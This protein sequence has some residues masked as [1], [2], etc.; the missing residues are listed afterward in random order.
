[1]KSQ[2]PK[3]IFFGTPEFSVKILEALR[4]NNLAPDLIIT[5]PDK[6]VGRKM[7]LTSSAVKTWAKTHNVPVEYDYKNLITLKPDIGIVASFGKIIPADILKIPRYG[8]LNV[9]P[10]LLPKFRG[11]SPIQS[12]ILSGD[13][14]TGV[15]IMLLNEK[16]D[17]GLILTNNKLQISNNIT[18]KEL[19]EKLAELG[20]K[21]LVETIPKW[22][23]GEIKP[24]LQ[25]HGKATYT[26]KIM[27]EDG[28][29]D[30]NEPPEIIDRKIRA[31]TPWPG[32]YTFSPRQTTRLNKRK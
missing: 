17:E 4:D 16:M 13:K 29:I 7:H 15:T 24:Q 22:I 20:G 32:A 19:E 31:F 9:H 25:D 23:N 26:K 1:M 28:L 30:W 10:S 21:L 12:A 14:E 2:K 18:A 5:A 11:S 3:I 6:P 27:K 8:F